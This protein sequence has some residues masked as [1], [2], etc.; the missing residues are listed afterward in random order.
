MFVVPAVNDGL[1]GRGLAQGLPLGP[2]LTSNVEED[3]T[4]GLPDHGAIDALVVYAPHDAG[5]ANGARLPP[6]KC[7]SR[8]SKGSCGVFL[9][10]E[11]SCPVTG[12]GCTSPASLI[13][14]PDLGASATMY[15]A[16]SD[17]NGFASC[18]AKYTSP[19]S[20]S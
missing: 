17:P 19:V 7:S 15:I 12:S 9:N 16:T 14:I 18:E 10:V 1:N 2:E 11:T 8:S 5:V 20:S 4:G 3:G 6:K 13:K